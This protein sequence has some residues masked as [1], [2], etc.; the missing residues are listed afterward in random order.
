M[1]PVTW[2]RAIG[3]AMVAAV[4]LVVL[5][6][7]V[8]HWLLTVLPIGSRALKAWLASGW[9]ALAFVGCTWAG[10]RASAPGRERR[11]GTDDRARIR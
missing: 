3:L 10:W 8:P 4:T 5:F 7:Y 1:G 2:G 9:V 6:F 11:V